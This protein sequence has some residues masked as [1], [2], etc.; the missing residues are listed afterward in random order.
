MSFGCT[1]NSY[2][3]IPSR[4][5]GVTFTASGR[6]TK[7]LTTNSR[8]ACISQSQRSGRSLGGPGDLSDKAGHRIARLRS[9]AEPILGPV[10]I[11]SKIIALLQR[12]VG[13]EFLE[14]LAIARAATVRHHNAEHGAVLCPD[15][16]HAYPDCHK[17]KCPLA[18]ASKDAGRHRFF[19]RCGFQK[20]GETSRGQWGW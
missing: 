16:F 19:L 10:V 20:R 12:L 18:A 3:V 17:V 9:F 4:S 5:T 1:R 11:Q 7:P 8:N 6:S 13:A 14:E 15:S 2:T